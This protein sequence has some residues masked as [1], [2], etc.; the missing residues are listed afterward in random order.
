[1]W[2]IAT[3]GSIPYELVHDDDIKKYL[4]D[5]NRLQKPLGCSDAL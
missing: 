1:M 5:D 2:E 3:R 4:E